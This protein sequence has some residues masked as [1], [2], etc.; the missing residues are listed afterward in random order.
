MEEKE[1]C[2]SLERTRSI[3][4]ITWLNERKD[5][6]MLHVE[7]FMDQSIWSRT[8]YMYM[9]TLREYMKDRCHL[10]RLS[11]EEQC[12]DYMIHLFGC[13]DPEDM[14]I[15]YVKI[16]GTHAGRKDTPD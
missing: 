5:D 14:I 7:Y 8:C 4:I 9:D 16:L 3:D 1:S 11:L 6:P 2:N 15:H 10:Q 13:K 12:K